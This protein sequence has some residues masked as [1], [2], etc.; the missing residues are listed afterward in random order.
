MIR[1]IVAL[2][3]MFFALH[4]ARAVEDVQNAVFVS[5][6][7][8]TAVTLIDP[9]N[10]TVEGTLDVGLVPRQIELSSSLGKLVVI[11]GETARLDLVDLAGRTIRE[12][13]LDLVPGR[14]AISTDGL[15]IALADLTGGRVVLIDLLSSK[16]LGFVDGLP[17]LRDMVF[18]VNNGALYLS[19]ARPGAIDVIDVTTGRLANSIA[20]GLPGGSR[21]LTRTA[22]GQ[23]LFVQS[24]G[25]GGVGVL[26]LEHAAPLIPIDTGPGST[27][28][29][30]SASGSFVLIADNQRETLTVVRQSTHVAPMV[31]PSD[32]GVRTIYATWFDTV[33]LLPSETEREVS[34][35]DLEAQSLLKKISL[36][37]A[38]GR[39]VVTPDGQK[40]YL[41]L[42]ETNEIAVVDARRQRLAATIRVAGNP[43]SV[44]MA[45]GYGLCH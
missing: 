40:L 23:R 9:D 21:A 4:S 19:G 26:D 6:A 16:Q 45:G 14:V 39:G 29:F 2:L 30:P 41:P 15:T 12:I 18:S 1:V 24:D 11:D 37:G 7:G 27:A 38:P 13:K 28:A 5:I 25:D 3:L 8:S 33:A 35:Y 10:D 34:I 31:L 36:D 22:N 43:A 17:A 44:V 20:T 32:S 42:S